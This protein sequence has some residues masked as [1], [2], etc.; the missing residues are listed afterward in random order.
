MF[1]AMI[2]TI[3]NSEFKVQ[4]D[5]LHGFVPNRDVLKKLVKPTQHESTQNE[6][7]EVQSFQTWQIFSY[8]Q[9]LLSGHQVTQDVHFLPV[10]QIFLFFEYSVVTLPG[11]EEF[12][13]FNVRMVVWWS[14]GNCG[15]RCHHRD[16]YR[17]I[18]QTAVYVCFLSLN[19]A[20]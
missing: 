1:V 7:V 9:K 17:T 2:A 20:P 10:I 3:I 8:Q 19:C 6:I 16:V 11:R 18:K 14:V 15:A 13:T 5:Y 4:V 12:G